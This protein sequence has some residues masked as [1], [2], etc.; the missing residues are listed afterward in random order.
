MTLRPYNKLVIN[1]RLNC[2]L[3]SLRFESINQIL[4][5]R[6]PVAQYIILEKLNIFIHVTYKDITSTI[7]YIII[8]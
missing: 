5:L 4:F 3:T 2:I 6:Q 1:D 7:F 8:R